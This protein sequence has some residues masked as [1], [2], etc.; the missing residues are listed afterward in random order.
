MVFCIMFG[1]GNRND[2]D[3]GVYSSIPTIRT[4][5]GPVELERSTERR[6]LWIK[7]IARNDLT[8]SILKYQRVCW[9]HFVSGKCRSSVTAEYCTFPSPTNAEQTLNYE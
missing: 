3:K 1:C 5:E 6:R 7:A 2:R 8:Q 9:K 4:N